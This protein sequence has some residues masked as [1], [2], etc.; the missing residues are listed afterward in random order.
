LGLSEERFQSLVDLIPAVVWTSGADGSI[1]YANKFWCNFTGMTLE[2]TQGSGWT[3]AVHP[4]DIQRVAE[5]WARALSAGEPVEV[6]FRIKGAEDGVY[7]S[8]LARSKPMRD[9]QGQ[10]VTWLGVFTLTD[11][12]R[13]TLSGAAFAHE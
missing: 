4:G 8:F 6:N 3:S 2:Q 12:H 10:I 1:D 13:G 11:H 5:V 9:R 7:H